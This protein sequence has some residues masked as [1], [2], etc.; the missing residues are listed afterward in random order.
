M[1]EK[2]MKMCERH[3]LAEMIYMGADG[4]LTKRRVQIISIGSDS[5]IAFCLLR[6]SRRTFKVERVLSVQQVV[7][8]EPQAI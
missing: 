1:R 7:H 8:R 5:F 3:E 6:R 2:L 4:S